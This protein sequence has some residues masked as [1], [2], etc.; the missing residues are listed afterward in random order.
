MTAFVRDDALRAVFAAMGQIVFLTAGYDECRAW[1]MPAGGDA[2][3]GASQIHTDLARGFV[4]AEVLAWSDFVKLYGDA[5]GRVGE[6]M[7]E[8][9]TAGLLRRRARRMSFGTGTSCTFWRARRRRRRTPQ[10]CRRITLPAD[11]GR[12][13]CGKSHA[14]FHV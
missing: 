9:R 3:V 14:P 13:G 10:S 11:A 5:K 12:P 8:A 1:A 7:K 4:R 6:S 2:V